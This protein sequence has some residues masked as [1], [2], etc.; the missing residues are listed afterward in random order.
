MT[1]YRALENSSLCPPESPAE[2]GLMTRK[3]VII[4]HHDELRE[5]LASLHLQ[6]QGFAVEWCQPFKGQSLSPPDDALAGAVILGGAPNVDQMDR[7]PFLYDEVRWIEQCLK[8]D[9][10][11]LGLCLGAQLIAHA[12]GA[13]VAPHADGAEEFGFYEILPSADAPGFV[14][15]GFLAA[16]Y[17]GRGFE[18]PS[19]AVSLARGELFPNQA[20]RFGQKVV[21]TQFHPECTQAMWRRWQAFPEAPW[22][23]PGAQSRDEQNRLAEATLARAGEW[24]I[25][26]LDQLF[27]PTLSQSA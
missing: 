3:I 1:R 11:T 12:L 20:F 7:S 16:Q 26:F 22:D 27:P 15:D 8:L 6:H 21:G 10:P 24:F 9:I 5:D 2:A 18:I 14:P 13:K 4:E 17:H 25:E 23:K 19:G